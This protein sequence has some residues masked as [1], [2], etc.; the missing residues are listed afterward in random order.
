MYSPFENAADINTVEFLNLPR[1]ELCTMKLEKNVGAK[2]L[3]TKKVKFAP[4]NT[5][6]ITKG[7]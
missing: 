1:I 4:P 7:I 3:I 5:P 2:A 6:T